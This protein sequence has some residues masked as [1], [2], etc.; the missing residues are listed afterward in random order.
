MRLGRGEKRRQGVITLHPGR[1]RESRRRGTFM[2]VGKEGFVIARSS[3][4]E[5][6]KIDSFD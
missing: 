4:K 5:E 6:Y 1:G 2:C 3:K